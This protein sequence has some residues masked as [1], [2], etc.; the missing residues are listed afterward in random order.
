MESESHFLKEDVSEYISILNNHVISCGRLG[1]MD[2]V[3]TTLDKFSKIKPNTFGDELSIHRQYYMNKFRLCI[4]TGEF[5]EGLKELEQ[6]KARMKKFDEKQFNL[7]TFYLQYFSIYFGV[8]DYKSAL[9]SLNEWLKLSR[10]IDRKD[11]Q[12]LA[13]ILNLI[14]HYELGNTLLLH[15]LLRSTYRYLNKENRLFDFERKVLSFIKDSTKVHS[16]KEMKK[17]FETLKEDFEKLSNDPSFGIFQMFDL[18]AWLESKISAKS[19][20]EVVKE[21]YQ[22]HLNKA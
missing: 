5:Q 14:I 22:R 18:I 20:A 17:T 21:R 9:E 13:R 6:H 4:S 19:F 16:K 10:N 3:R 8:R 15:S 11:L 12:S 7:N 1:K 2:E